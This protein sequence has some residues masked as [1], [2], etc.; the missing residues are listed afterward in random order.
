MSR[1]KRFK[2]SPSIADPEG[3]FQSAIVILS[4]EPANAYLPELPSDIRL[5]MLSDAASIE[6]ELRAEVIL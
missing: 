4:H 3:I 6:A 2:V 5:T 1:L